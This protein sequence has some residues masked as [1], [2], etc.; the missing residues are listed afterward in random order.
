M[1]KGVAYGTNNEK[2]VWLLEKNPLLE[3][4]GSAPDIS[5]IMVTHA[6]HLQ[7]D[8]GNSAFH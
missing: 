3:Y 7:S 6:P 5:H 8:S 4:S 1:N 2:W